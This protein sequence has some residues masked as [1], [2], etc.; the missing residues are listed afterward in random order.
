MQNADDLAPMR[1]PA[2]VK[3]D[4][5]TVIKPITRM[6][7]AARQGLESPPRFVINKKT[8]T[9]SLCR[10][11]FQKKKKNQSH[12]RIAWARRTPARFAWS[13]VSHAQTCTCAAACVGVHFVHS[14][15]HIK[16]RSVCASLRVRAEM[17]G[18]LSV[19][20]L[21]RNNWV[22]CA[23]SSQGKF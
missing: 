6:S 2:C 11:F 8:T 19:L 23:N 14:L 18:L 17:C 1:P 16:P 12:G 21:E 20:S 13:G 9:G 10:I 3:K 4:N 22:T 15:S 7:S 5:L